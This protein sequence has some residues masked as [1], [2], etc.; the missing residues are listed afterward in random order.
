M[1]CVFLI[2]SSNVLA[3]FSRNGSHQYPEWMNRTNEHTH[4]HTV[5]AHCTYATVRCVACGQLHGCFVAL[6]SK[7]IFIDNT[8]ELNGRAENKINTHKSISLWKK[9][10]RNGEIFLMEKSACQTNDKH[11]I[12]ISNLLDAFYVPEYSW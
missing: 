3:L 12:F 11:S 8:K 10:K 5:Y 1:N 9:L 2:V 7:Y 4:I 6:L